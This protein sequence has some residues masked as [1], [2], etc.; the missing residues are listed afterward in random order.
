M[1][2]DKIVKTTVQSIHWALLD[3]FAFFDNQTLPV[4]LIVFRL[5]GATWSILDAI[6]APTRFWRGSQNR[7]SLRVL[8]N[9]MEQEIQETRLNTYEFL[10]NFWYRNGGPDIVKKNVWH[11]NSC[12]L[13][14]FGGRE[15]WS[16]KRWPKSSNSTKTSR[17]WRCKVWIL[18]FWRFLENVDFLMNFRS[19]KN[20]PQNSNLRSDGRQ[21]VPGRKG[22]RKRR[23][24]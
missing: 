16:N 11:Y 12:K 18:S 24:P 15:K 21:G 5:F 1:K 19:A 3:V 14:K 17:P 4:S 10:T 23:G 2:K 22:R 8:K 6:L 7:W 13:G 20:R 9:T